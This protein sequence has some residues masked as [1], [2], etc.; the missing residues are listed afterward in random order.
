MSSDPRTL[1]LLSDLIRFTEPQVIVEVGT[2]RGWGTATF[3]ETLRTYNLP[4]HV[5]SCD[6]VDHG[7][8]QMLKQAELSDRV[9]LIQGTFEELLEASRSVWSNFTIDFCYIDASHKDEPSLRLRYTRLALE[10]LAPGGIIAVDDAA[11]DWRGA[12]SLRKLASLY[13][14]QHRGLALI[15]S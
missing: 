5:W 11:G 15:T 1:N 3:A 10:Y 12:K 9:T 7:V 14:P 6:P 2:Y 4:G 13:L 8:S